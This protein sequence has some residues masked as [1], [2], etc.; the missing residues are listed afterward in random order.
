M[1]AGASVHTLTMRRDDS[2]APRIQAMTSWSCRAAS[3]PMPPGSTTVSIGCH[4][5]GS[6][7]ATISSPVPVSIGV[8]S[9]DAMVTS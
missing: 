9:S 1:S 5:S 2:A 3:M 8:P 4:G 6:G 7:L